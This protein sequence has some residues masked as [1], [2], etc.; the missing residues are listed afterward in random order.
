MRLGGLE[1][2]DGVLGRDIDVYIDETIG[3]RFFELRGESVERKR[4]DVFRRG[5]RII[6]TENGAPWRCFATRYT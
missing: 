4:N 6:K 1:V 5:Y 3:E 2:M